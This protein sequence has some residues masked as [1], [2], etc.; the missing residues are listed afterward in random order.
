MALLGTLLTRIDQSLIAG[1][2]SGAVM[3]VSAES[4]Q[5]RTTTLDE[6]CVFFSRFWPVLLSTAA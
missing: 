2:C 1:A 5:V 3:Q 4:V 6:A